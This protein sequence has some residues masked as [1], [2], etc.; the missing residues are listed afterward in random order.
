VL[1]P[2]SAASNQTT[3]ASVSSKTVSTTATTSLRTTDLE[4]TLF[5]DWNGDG[6]QQP[7]EPTLRDIPVEITGIDTDYK[8][9]LL[10]DSDGR[11]WARNIPVGKQYH[12]V[13]KTDRFRYLAISNADFRSM[14]D[15]RYFLD[16]PEPSLK[17][18]L[19]E[20]FLTLAFDNTVPIRIQSYP[21]L[22]PRP[23]YIRDWRGGTKTYD[24]HGGTDFLMDKKKIRAGA[25]GLLYVAAKGWPDNPLF[26]GDKIF[27]ASGNFIWIDHL[28]GYYSTY[29][30][31]EEIYVDEVYYGGNTEKVQRGQVIGLSGQTGQTEVPHLHMGCVHNRH[32]LDL[33]RDLFYDRYLNTP[34][35]SA[36]SNPLSLWTKDNDPQF[37]L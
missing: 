37:S 25:A 7:D 19:M 22:D 14:I 1:K 26:A 23:V 3:T 15:Y 21:D 35:Q 12:L 16:T 10:P 6:G 27:K 11:Y 29:N 18:A 4:L 30:H 5:A 36:V 9:V 13:P 31:L 8:A 34:L 24:G 20:G 33:Y 2:P 17:L 28:N 32:D